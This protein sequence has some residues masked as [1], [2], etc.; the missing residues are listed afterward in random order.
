VLIEC[1]PF[2]FLFYALSGKRKAVT[3]NLQLFGRPLYDMYYK[4]ACCSQ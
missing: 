3:R 2:L 4:F 1:E